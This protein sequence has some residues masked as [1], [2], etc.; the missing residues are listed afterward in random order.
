MT[1]VLLN[2]YELGNTVGE[3]SSYGLVIIMA[4]VWI[5]VMFKYLNTSDL[6]E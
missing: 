1:P 2:M 6:N 4:I 5:W 3:V